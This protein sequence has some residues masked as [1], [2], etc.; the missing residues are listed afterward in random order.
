MYIHM[1]MY[2]ISTICTYSHTCAHAYM[3]TC[4]HTHLTVQTHTCDHAYIHTY[5]TIHTYIRICKYTHTHTSM[6][7]YRHTHACMCGCSCMCFLR[8]CSAG[9][10][11]VLIRVGMHIL[12]PLS[13]YRLNT[14]C[15]EGRK[16]SK[17]SGA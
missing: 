9:V 16:F 14:C 5:T 10:W 2:I 8:D 17:L 7:A 12:M 1:N 15:F 6:H 13:L 11:E 4:T 3:H